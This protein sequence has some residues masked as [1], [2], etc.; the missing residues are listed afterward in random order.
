MSATIDPNVLTMPSP[1]QSS[2][3]DYNDNNGND[4]MT[5]HS[6]SPAASIASYL[7]SP[8]AASSSRK[9]KASFNARPPQNI[10]D[11]A[12]R[13]LCPSN[14]R[15]KPMSPERIARLEARQAR[16]RASAQ[17]SR[18]KKKAFISTLEVEH[19]QLCKENVMLKQE[20]AAMNNK[21]SSLENRLKAMESMIKSILDPASGQSSL[22]SLPSIAP[23]IPSSVA[24]TS[25][26]STTALNLTTDAASST[27]FATAPSAAPSSSS[28]ATTSTS[29]SVAPAAPFAAPH[30][31]QEPV[32][33][34][35]EGSESSARLPAVEAFTQQRA[36]FF[37]PPVWLS[38][39][40]TM[41]FAQAR[42]YRS[43]LHCR[44]STANMWLQGKAR[45]ETT[46]AADRAYYRT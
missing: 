36:L 15:A 30:I 18:D 45:Q 26:S 35:T 10:D 22:V 1:P 40:P 29:L 21:M 20:N 46:A 12:Q 37:P 13:N 23:C 38:A 34:W 16:N 44:E 9:R 3:P 33:S 27:T 28:L 31:K 43:R 42:Q 2:S 8:A 32:A 19:K 17:A 11:P 6:A 14:K 39:A 25:I 5:C 7:S 24:S 41:L 4:S